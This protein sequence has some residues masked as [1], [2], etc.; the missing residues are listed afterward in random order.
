[1]PARPGSTWISLTARRSTTRCEPTPEP[2]PEKT[3]YSHLL[4][5]HNSVSI[6]VFG[7]QAPNVRGKTVTNSSD[8]L[9]FNF[10]Y[11][12]RVLSSGP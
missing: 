6:H 1:M 12:F 8:L 11:D 2:L 10:A 7:P 3:V 4:Q 5:F 9:Y